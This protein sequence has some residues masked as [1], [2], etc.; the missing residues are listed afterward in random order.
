MKHSIKLLFALLFATSFTMS[1][2]QSVDEIVTNYI[3]NIGFLRLK[4]EPERN[5]KGENIFLFRKC[6][7]FRKYG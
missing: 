5:R 2:A 3:E 4:K 7:T 6:N 1:N